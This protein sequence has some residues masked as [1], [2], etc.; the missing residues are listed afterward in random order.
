MRRLEV[1]EWGI[2]EEITRLVLP[3]SDGTPPDLPLHLRE[4]CWWLNETNSSF[5]L[6]FLSPYLT[7][8]AISTNALTRPFEAVDPWDQLPDEVVLMMCAAIKMFPASPQIV[9]LKLGIEPETRLTEEFSTY[10][11][12]CGDA[13]QKFA[14]NVVLSTQAIVHLMKLPNLRDWTTWQRP[15]QVTDLVR[16]GVLDCVASLFPSLLKLDLWGEV[17]LEWLSLFEAVKNR[18]PPWIMAG[19]SLPMVSCGHST[20]PIDSS[21]ISRF[22]PFADLVDLRIRA[23]CFFRSCVSKFTDEDAERL[24]AAL[25]KLEVVTLG[26]CPCIPDTCPTTVRSLLSFSIH[27]QKLKYLNIHFHTSD[28][29]ADM[30]DLLGN[31]YSQNLHSKPKCVLET[32]APHMLPLDLSDCNPALFSMGMLMIFPSLT[33]LASYSPEWVQLEVLVKA[34]RHD[35]ECEVATEELMRSLSEAMESVGNDIRTLSAVSHIPFCLPSEHGRKCLFIDDSF[36]SQLQDETARV[37]CEPIASKL[38]EITNG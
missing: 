4:L 34:M 12:G 29:R 3:L 9:C 13:L 28:L 36:C 35:R 24:T 27:C 33:K 14:T 19:D 32:L 17:S 8:I 20:L 22:L 30:L 2:S 23:K 38:V 25:P 21:L 16:H 15:P 5:L 10:V 11:L 26:E 37:L 7:T 31:A 18:D 6:N 1:R